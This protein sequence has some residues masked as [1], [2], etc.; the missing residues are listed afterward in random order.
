M[1]APNKKFRVQRANGAVI[2]GETAARCT[3]IWWRDLAALQSVVDDYCVAFSYQPQISDITGVVENP[4]TPGAFFLRML[5]TQINDTVRRAAE[6][7]AARLQ[8]PDLPDSEDTRGAAE[9]RTK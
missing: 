9:V 2:D 7:K 4:E 3:A 8:D 6:I 1:P 5:R